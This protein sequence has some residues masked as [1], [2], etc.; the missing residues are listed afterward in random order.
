MALPA[1]GDGAGTVIAAVVAANVA[2]LGWLGQAVVAGLVWDYRRRTRELELVI[3]L[4]AEIE[5]CLPLL[6]LYADS[7]TVGAI[8]KELLDRPNYRIFIPLDREYFVFERVKDDLSLLPEAT[9]SPIVKFYDAI[10]SFDTLIASFQEGRFEAFPVDRKTSYVRHM[11]TVSMD[12]AGDAR[13]ALAAIDHEK[14]R[15]GKRLKWIAVVAVTSIVW[16]GATMTAA[17]IGGLRYLGLI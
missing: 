11:R 7:R 12:I 15:I 17:V 9:I 1:I 4:R 10:G 2:V 5:A 16:I 13:V 6:D 3:A 14:P 8:E